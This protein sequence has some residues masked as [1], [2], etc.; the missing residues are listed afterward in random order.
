MSAAAAPGAP[1]MHP[2]SEFIDNL[3][4][5]MPQQDVIPC[6]G[7]VS[8]IV[9]RHAGAPGVIGAHRPLSTGRL[10]QGRRVDDESCVPAAQGGVRFGVYTS[11]MTTQKISVLGVSA[12]PV[13]AVGR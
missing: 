13:G 1:L 5:E 8:K 4:D 12:T 7:T 6:G 3:V 10:V 9:A 2:R 11:P